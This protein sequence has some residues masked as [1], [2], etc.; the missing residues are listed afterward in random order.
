MM[1]VLVYKDVYKFTH[2][3]ITDYDIRS[4]NPRNWFFPMCW[5]LYYCW[6]EHEKMKLLLTQCT[7]EFVYYYVWLIG[8]D[9]YVFNW[10]RDEQSVWVKQ[11]NYQFY[12]FK[13][14]EVRKIEFACY[15]FCVMHKVLLHIH[16]SPIIYGTHC[17]HRRYYHPSYYIPKFNLFLYTTIIQ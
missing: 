8:L 1:H 6:P 9:D 17:E 11:K 16:N 3:S 14:L 4:R 5:L 13:K 12:T 10:K 7:H 2:G 15:S